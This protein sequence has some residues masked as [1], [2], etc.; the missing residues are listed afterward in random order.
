MELASSTTPA[1]LEALLPHLFASGFSHPLINSFLRLGLPMTFP[2]GI[3]WSPA[4]GRDRGC[5]RYGRCF[6][7]W[8][9]FS[10]EVSQQVDGAVP[11]AAQFGG[12]YDAV[13][14]TLASGTDCPDEH[15]ELVCKRD[16]PLV[17]QISSQLLFPCGLGHCHD[18]SITCC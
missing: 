6:L 16:K 12:Q 7:L 3:D 1:N 13:K 2:R 4:T 18:S 10:S 14:R 17:D 5:C 9:V 15:T 8:R 11:N